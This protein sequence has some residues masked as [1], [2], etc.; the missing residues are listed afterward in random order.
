MK[1]YIGMELGSTRIKS[2]LVDEAGR[3]EASGSYTWENQLE[4]GLWTYAEAEIWKG[5]QE[6]FSA[7]MKDM[8]I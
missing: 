5:V 3:A 4:N 6:S 8:S 1:T 7:L 2:V